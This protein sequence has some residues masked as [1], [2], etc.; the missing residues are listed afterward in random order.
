MFA[1]TIRS[2]IDKRDE[3]IIFATISAQMFSSVHMIFSLE[4]LKASVTIPRIQHNDRR[5]EEY[6]VNKK[7]VKRSKTI[8]KVL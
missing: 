3:V 1:I 6:Q 7:K 5:S 2:L 8:I 4:Y